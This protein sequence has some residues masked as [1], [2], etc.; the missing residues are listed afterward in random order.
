MFRNSVLDHGIGQHVDQLIAVNP[1]ANMDHKTVPRVLVDQVQKTHR[2]SIM[3]VC[4]HEVAG[5]CVIQPLRPQAHLGAV[6]EPQTA[7]RLLR[8]LQ[9]FAVPD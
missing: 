4:T 6:V 8:N 3:A 7:S 1:A 9:P 5:P 2:L